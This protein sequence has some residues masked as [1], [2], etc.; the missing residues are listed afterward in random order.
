MSARATQRDRRARRRG[1]A[2]RRRARARR[3]PD[4]APAGARQAARLPRQRRHRAEAARG[5]RRDR[6]LLRRRDNANIHRGVHALSR[7]RHRGL[8]GA[9]ATR[10]SA[11]S[12]PRDREEIIFVRGTTEAHQ[13]GRAELR[14]ARVLQ[15]GDE[16]VISA[17]EHHSNIVP[18]QMLCRERGAVLRVVPIERR[19]RARC[20]TS[21]R[22]CSARARSWSR[23]V[24]RLQRARHGQPGRGD[25]RRWRT[26]AASRCWSTAPRRCRTC[27]STCRRSTATSTP[28]PATSCTARP[29]SACCTAR[30]RCSRR[31]RRTRAAAT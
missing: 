16:I 1:A 4:P 28:S 11:S 14:R 20:S 9:R 18:W 29:A 25:H 13:P 12:T 19:R 22:S 6:A 24:A 2:V 5:D 31:C 17:M 27:R 30:R 10:C 21:T 26:R 15:P 23:V 8:R 3:L 7:A